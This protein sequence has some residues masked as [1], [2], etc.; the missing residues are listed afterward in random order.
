MSPLTPREKIPEKSRPTVATHR[1]S[2]PALP[3]EPGTSRKK[4][5]LSVQEMLARSFPA[6]AR[7]LVPD[8]ESART[9]KLPRDLPATARQVD[10]MVHVRYPAMRRA[11]VPDRERIVIVEFQVQRDRHLHQAMLLR[12]A[13]AHSL[14]RRK[15]KTLVLALTPQAVV[16]T[17]HVFGEGPDSD[18]VRH[19]VIVREVF[20]ESAEAALAT[21][22]AALLP[23]VSTMQPRDGD[24][25]ALLTR[26]VERILALGLGKEQQTMMLE[27][28]AHLATLHLPRAIVHDIVQNSVRRGSPMLN[29]R[30]L[31]YAKSVYR[32][33]KA[34]GRAEGKAEGKAEGRVI[35]KAESVVTILAARGVSVSRALRKQILACTDPA[36]LDRWLR[37]AASAQSVADVFDAN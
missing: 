22:I 3:R 13:L 4:Y 34:E 37:R 2:P 14:Y 5:D 30:Q 32:E 7:W 9:L 26:I 21:G 8:A 35:G 12:A 25:A 33:G 23:L 1:G 19:R 6:L 17:D 18:D 29:L 28:A 31:P 27:Q 15:V 11:S 20:R 10:L 36:T 24:H 16:P